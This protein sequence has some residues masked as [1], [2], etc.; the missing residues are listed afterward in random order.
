M[1]EMREI[2][3]GG[4]LSE[5]KIKV[6]RDLEQRREKKD[7]KAKR[8]CLEKKHKEKNNK[9][10]S[11]TYTRPQH[12]VFLDRKDDRVILAL[13]IFYVVRVPPSS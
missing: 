7:W 8:T 1:N 11:G 13:K 12:V 4:S 3:D 5:K 9:G 2:T 6:K 10:E